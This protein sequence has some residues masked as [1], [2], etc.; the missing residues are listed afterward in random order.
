MARHPLAAYTRQEVGA[1]AN[2]RMEAAVAVI[3]GPSWPN[4]AVDLRV[5]LRDVASFIHKAMDRRRR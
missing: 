5:C 3:L 2:G 1:V 4:A